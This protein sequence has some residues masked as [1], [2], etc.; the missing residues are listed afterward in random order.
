MSLS[1]QE[2]SA[3]ASLAAVLLVFWYY[4]SAV[5]ALIRADQLHAASAIGLMIGAV[6]MLVI[7]EIV[8]QIAVAILSGGTDTDERDKL[9]AAKA[10]RNSG[11]L[12]G[13]GALT[14]IMAILVSEVR[15]GLGDNEFVLTPIIIAQIILCLIVI[16][17]VFEYLSQL[18]YYR[19][20]A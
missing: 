8:F 20:G 19:R 2:K 17:Q 12:L 18:Y 15:G 1:Y 4:F 11:F 6:V 10:G 14:T 5:L 7:I 16:A 13:F 9:I 3:I